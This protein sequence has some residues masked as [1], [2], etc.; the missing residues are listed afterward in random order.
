MYG[1][2]GAQE[3]TYGSQGQAYGSQGQPYGGA[4]PYDP[5]AQ[6]YGSQE[7]AYGSQGQAY[8]SQGQPYGDAYAA[9]AQ[10]FQSQ[11]TPDTEQGAAQA[12]ALGG[13]AAAGSTADEGQF[14]A[15]GQSPETDQSTADGQAYLGA[16]N[17]TS[18]AFAQSEPTQ[19]FAAG[20]FGAG[21]FGEPEPTPQSE[22]AFDDQTAPADAS[23][24]EH[25]V[26]ADESW[27]APEG[28]PSED[29]LH[30]DSTVHADA[31]AEDGAPSEDAAAGS[32]FAP[33]EQEAP[34]EAGHPFVASQSAWMEEPADT[35][36]DQP[37][38]APEATAPEYAD[39]FAGADAPTADGSDTHEAEGAGLH[40]PDAA[41]V[42]AA[43]ET[44][45]PVEPAASGAEPAEQGSTDQPGDAGTDAEPAERPA[46]SAPTPA[47]GDPQEGSAAVDAPAGGHFRGEEQGG[48]ENEPTQWFRVGGDSSAP[49]EEGTPAPSYD[50]TQGEPTQ[51]FKPVVSQM[52]WFAVTEPRPAVD[53]VTGQE[54]FTVTPNEWFLALEDH[55]SFFKVRDAH[56]Q[57]GYLNNVEGIIRG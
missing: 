38:V 17:A 25:S 23:N 11:P 47:D 3:Q 31:H 7:Q 32:E 19:A 43:E 57:E 8:G 28:A 53:P 22:T 26:P 39:S 20:A 35:A 33:A 48:S 30:A 34:A 50:A 12:D 42:A 40:E 46:A 16:E 45:I 37:V 52:F 49:A 5:A 1:A 18:P 29:A 4:A 41:D 44:A 51:A 24:A 14:A 21:A 2:A 36:D 55:G 6:Q 13:H 15:Y 10:S 54:I 9:Q 56:G 27:T